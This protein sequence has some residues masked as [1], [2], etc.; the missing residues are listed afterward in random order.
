[1]TADAHDEYLAHYRSEISQMVWSHLSVTHS[2][3]KNRDGQIF[4][5]SP[6]PIPTYWQWTRAVDPDH[7]RFE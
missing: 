1:M 4:T 5:L 7:Y 2:H 3:F 6:W